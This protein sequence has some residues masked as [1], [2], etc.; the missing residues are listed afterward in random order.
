[1]PHSCVILENLYSD[2]AFYNDPGKNYP[3]INEQ[4]K[5]CKKIAQSLTSQINRR[6]RGAKMF[7]KR[8]RKSSKWVHEG[9]SEWS[10]SAGDVANLQEL[11][12][13]LSPDEG[14]SKPLFY[15]KIPNLKSRI[16]NTDRKMALTQEQFEKLRLQSMKCDHKVVPP[17]QCFDL[18][19]D[20]K[21]SKGRGGRMFE[22]RKSRAEK[23]VVDETNARRTTPRAKLEHVLSQ[24][25]YQETTPWNAAIQDGG[26]VDAAFSHI[27]EIQRN[28]KLNQI[29][30]Y[31][32]PRKQPTT[33]MPPAYTPTFQTSLKRDSQNVLM[34][35]KCFNRSAK[36]W[37]GGGEYPVGKLI[38]WL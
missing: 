25:V 8:K 29:L 27:N 13:E 23:Y 6:A 19:A 28:Q 20:L 16:S 24:P 3:T 17:N 15:F 10:S 31:S 37:S 22:K 21:A 12:S 34:K 35:G 4:I 1:M 11:D 38:A 36:G 5:L 7:M 30:R 9:H 14:G 2:S 26:N 18:V 32:D 33:P